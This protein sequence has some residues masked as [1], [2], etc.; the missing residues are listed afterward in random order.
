VN[1]AR[2]EVTS[3]DGSQRSAAST[4]DGYFELDRVPA[5]TIQISVTAAGFANWQT[6]ALISPNA[7]LAEDVR[8]N[9][10]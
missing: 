9:P 10:L 7:T 4:A 3:A 1:G 6:N 8:L 5:G 2:I